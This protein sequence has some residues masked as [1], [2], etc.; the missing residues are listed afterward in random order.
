MN[1]K[2]PR[3]DERIIEILTMFSEEIKTGRVREGE[4][5]DKTACVLTAYMAGMANDSDQRENE[6]FNTLDKSCKSVCELTGFSV[7]VDGLH[8]NGD[9]TL[10]K[11]LEQGAG[12]KDGLLSLTRRCRFCENT[13][14]R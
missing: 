4:A 12:T 11:T 7:G 5:I 6:L 3:E 1:G 9:V 10:G 8:L 14:R 2:I 13:N